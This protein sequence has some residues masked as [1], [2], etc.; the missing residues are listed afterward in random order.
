[1]VA[2]QVW[3]AESEWV[4]ES[5]SQ[6]TGINDVLNMNPVLSRQRDVGGTQVI[7]VSDVGQILDIGMVQ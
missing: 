3:Y 2:N 1:M 6:W 4:S 5:A 7:Q